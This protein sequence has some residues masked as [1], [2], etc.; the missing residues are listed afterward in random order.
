MSKKREL[1]VWDWRGLVICYAPNIA[2]LKHLLLT[3]SCYMDSVGGSCFPSIDTLVDV[4]SMSRPTILKYLKIAQETGWI[5]VEKHGLS[6]QQWARNQYSANVPIDVI[7]QINKHDDSGG[8]AVK[9]VNRVNE[10]AVNPFNEGGKTDSE[11]RLTSLYSN[12]SITHQYLSKEKKGARE[13]IDKIL[14][15]IHPPQH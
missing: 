13:Q 11:R 14:K 9:E 12:S 7:S 8:K 15:G 2:P 5:E 6:G 1:H 4:T 10:K 3:L